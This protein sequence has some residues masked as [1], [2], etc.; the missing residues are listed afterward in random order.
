M[1]VVGSLRVPAATRS[2]PR[3]LF[4]RMSAIGDVLFAL[5]ALRALRRAQP[6]A[7]IAWLVED[8][9]ASIVERIA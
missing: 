5:P 6:E 2:G 9:A 7:H 4:I 3:I 1:A 8:R